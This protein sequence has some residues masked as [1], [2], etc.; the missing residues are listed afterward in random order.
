MVKQKQKRKNMWKPVEI[1][2]KERA[3]E[4]ICFEELSDYKAIRG[5]DTYNDPEDIE[6]VEKGKNCASTS[7]LSK[8][9]NPVTVDDQSKKKKKKKKK[10]TKFEETNI[11]SPDQ[12]TFETKVDELRGMSAWNEFG[13][14]EQI[15]RALEAKNFTSPTEIQ[16]RKISF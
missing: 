9:R 4:L 12:E 1:N 7:A 13:L 8:R 2:L 5:K 15:I 16:V 11:V 3:P 6:V 14:S 10:I